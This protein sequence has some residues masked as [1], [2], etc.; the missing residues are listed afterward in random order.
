M[1]NRYQ[2]GQIYADTHALGC[3]AVNQGQ[4]PPIPYGLHYRSERRLCAT[5]QGSGL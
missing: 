5:V 2:I 1:Y 3:L 4:H